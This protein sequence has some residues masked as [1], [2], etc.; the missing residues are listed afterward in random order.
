MCKI[1]IVHFLTYTDEALMV[2]YF[3][4]VMIEKQV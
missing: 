1:R 4:A 3:N 2:V